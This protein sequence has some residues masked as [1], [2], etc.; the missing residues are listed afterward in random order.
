M[1]FAVETFASWHEEAAP[2]FRA[3][4][5]LVGRHRDLMPLKI[6]VARWLRIER[7]GLALGFSARIG[8]RLKG[9]A[10]YLLNPSLNYMGCTVGYC[11]AI[12]VDPAELAGMKARRFQRFIDFCDAELKRRGCVKAVMHMKLTHNFL[13]MIAPLGYEQSEILAERVL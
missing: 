5:E 10:M 9:Y 8:W 12:Y 7:E 3:H 13:R 2:L 1:R 11:H 6:D 4:W